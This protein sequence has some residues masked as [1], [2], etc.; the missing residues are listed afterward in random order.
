[1]LYPTLATLAYP[2]RA[3]LLRVATKRHAALA[4]SP[5][6]NACHCATLIILYQRQLPAGSTPSFSAL[7]ILLLRHCQHTLRFTRMQ[8]L[9]SIPPSWALL[10]G[11]A[12][13]RAYSFACAGLRIFFLFF[14]ASDAP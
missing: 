13:L 10:E 3:G 7:H 11:H 12:A 14:C 8:N 5:A 2:N 9:F 1:L 6:C 4:G